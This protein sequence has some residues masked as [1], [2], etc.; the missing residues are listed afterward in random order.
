MGG[1]ESKSQLLKDIAQAI[2]VDPTEM[3]LT[4]TNEDFDEW[5]SMGVL[6]ILTML[7]SKYGLR[8]GAGEASACNSVAGIV[9]LLES[10]DLLS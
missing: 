8:V 9:Q 3:S 1:L 6:E 5:D 2:H 7:D 4:S 10:K